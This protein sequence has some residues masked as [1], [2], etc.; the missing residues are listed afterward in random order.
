MSSPDGRRVGYQGEPGA[1]SEEAALTLLPGAQTLGHATFRLAFDALSEGEVDVAVLPVENTLG[2][3]VQEVNDLLWETPG[4]RVTGEYV[5]PVAHCLLGRDDGPVRRAMSHYQA[6]A[7][8]RHWLHDHGIEPVDG[9]DTAGSARWLAANPT[10]GT[11][12]VASAR[13]AELYGL[14]ILASGIQDDDSN[15]TRFL[16]VDRGEPAR[17]GRGSASGRVSLAFVTAHRPGSLVASLQC[18]SALGQN[19]TRLDSRPI[20]G[21]PFEY[22][23]YVDFDFTDPGQ[24][25]ASLRALE[26]VAAEVCLFGSYPTAG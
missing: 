23:F 9:G 20:A 14:E 17:P 3:I 7:Q 5:H 4:L 15:R 8:C 12:A 2:G 21:R 16:I 11:A 13:C 10:P 18:F 22:R 26:G 25:E 1:Y 19:L 6:L 24:A